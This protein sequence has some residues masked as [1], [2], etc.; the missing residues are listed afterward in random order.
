MQVRAVERS[1]NQVS[2][3]IAVVGILAS[4]GTV[5]DGAWPYCGQDEL[6][7][8]GKC[9]P[10]DKYFCKD[11]HPVAFSMRQGHEHRCQQ[12]GF[13]YKVRADKSHT[14]HVKKGDWLNFAIHGTGPR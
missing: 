13:A 2:S 8:G 10:A 5:K 3:P 7:C 11:G 12:H 6:G 14:I 9:Y 1:T 4:S